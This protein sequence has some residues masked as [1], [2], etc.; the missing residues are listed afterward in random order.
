MLFWRK[1]LFVPAAATAAGFKKTLCP[2]ALPLAVA[3]VGGYP[4]FS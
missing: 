3:G 2:D 4:H 1:D